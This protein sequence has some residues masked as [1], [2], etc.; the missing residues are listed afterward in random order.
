MSRSDSLAMKQLCGQFVAQLFYNEAH[1]Y[2]VV[3]F[4]RSWHNQRIPK[5]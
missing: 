2:H 4:Y 1:L 3:A 5:E